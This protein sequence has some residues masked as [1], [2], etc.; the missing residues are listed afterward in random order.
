VL[1]TGWQPNGYRSLDPAD[2]QVYD[3]FVEVRRL[4][5]TWD[6]ATHYAFW[7]AGLRTWPTAKGQVRQ[8]EARAYWVWAWRRRGVRD[9]AIAAHLGV[10]LDTLRRRDVLAAAATLDE[11]LPPV[12]QRPWV[13]APVVIAPEHD[14]WP[15]PRSTWYDRRLPDREPSDLARALRTEC[16]RAARVPPR[17]A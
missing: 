17:A 8:T 3:D 5:N 12:D 16:S 9:S 14:V 13:R 15:D 4:Q 2:G 10:E 6:R 11:P 7:T 1:V